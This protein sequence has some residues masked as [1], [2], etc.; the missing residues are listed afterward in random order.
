MSPFELGQVL[1][2]AEELEKA[3]VRAQAAGLP[4]AT[5]ERKHWDNL[6]ALE[7]IQAYPRGPVADIGCRSG[8][9]LTWLYVSGFSDLYGCDIK[10]PYPPLKSA[11]TQMKLRTAAVGARM[12]LANRK[13]MRVAP[14]ENTG[15]PDS[16]FSAVTAMSVIEHSVDTPAFF[17]E[18]RRILQP[19]GILFVSTDYWPE[20]ARQGLDLVFSDD[21]V[22]RLLQEAEASSLR[23][24]GQPDRTPGD[25]LIQEGKL[26][27]TFLTLAFER[28]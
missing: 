3:A 20:G 10:R 4:P 7:A 23:P 9:L 11:L 1:R 5:D 27:Y 19:G 8:I 26:S 21:D 17:A 18:V 12:Y 13:N 15:F 16:F 2:T 22:D 28:T 14:A 25:P 6:Q 24:L